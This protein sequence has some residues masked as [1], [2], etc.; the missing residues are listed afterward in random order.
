MAGES[1]PGIAAEVSADPNAEEFIVG[2]ESLGGVLQAA[3]DYDREL[4]ARESED[5]TDLEALQLIQT[6][7]E[8]VEGRPVVLLLA[9]QLP[10]GLIRPTTLYRSVVVEPVV[11][12]LWA[13]DSQNLVDK[14]CRIGIVQ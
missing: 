9:R 7:F 8:D 11:R 1:L 12:Q 2:P 13:M 4:Q 14:F 10:A 5:F 6:G 3:E